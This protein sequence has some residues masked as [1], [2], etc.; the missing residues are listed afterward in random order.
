LFAVSRLI[1][2]TVGT[3]LLNTR[4]PPLSARLCLSDRF[5]RDGADLTADRRETINRRLD[6]LAHHLDG[7]PNPKSL[8]FKALAG[9]PLG[10]GVTHEAYAWSDGAAWRLYG[11][12]DGGVFEVL[13]LGEH[14]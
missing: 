13:C 7:G 8:S 10:Q 11:R 9:Q 3:R 1:V 14:L 6:D 4:L 2:S 5:E 12:F